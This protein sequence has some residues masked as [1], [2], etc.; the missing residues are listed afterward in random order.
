MHPIIHLDASRTQELGRDRESNN[1]ESDR[2]SLLSPRTSTERLFV[3]GLF[4]IKIA[5]TS[6]SCPVQRIELASYVTNGVHLHNRLHWLLLFGGDR[7]PADSDV[8]NTQ[9]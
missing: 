7:T 5:L 4:V 1:S 3:T 9:S 6:S 8:I 2:L